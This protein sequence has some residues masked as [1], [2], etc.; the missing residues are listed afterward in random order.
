VLPAPAE[1]RALVIGVENYPRLGE[2]FR[3]PRAAAA[4]ADFARW[5]VRGRGVDIGSVELWLNPAEGVDPAQLCR[6]ADLDGI[7][8]RR[9]EWAAFRDAVETPQ[10]VFATGSFLMV[11]FCGHGLVSGFENAHYLVLPEASENQYHCVKLENWRALF[12]NELWHR[13]SHQLWTVDA[14]RNQWGVGLPLNQAGWEPGKA[15]PVKRCL[16]SSCAEGEVMTA[17]FATG[18]RYTGEL[19][20]CLQDDRAQPWPD[21]VQA[22]HHIAALLRETGTA[23]QSPTLMLESW[24]GV[25]TIDG[26][27][28]GQRLL[29]LLDQIGW[30]FKKFLPYV[31]RAQAM[32]PIGF[33]P[34]ANLRQALEQLAQLAPV[35]D[36]EPI[37]DFAAR[38]AAARDFPE[39]REW[40]ESSLSPRQK[41]ELAARRRED[42]AFLRLSLWYRSDAAQ[43]SMDGWLDV[44]D[45]G[46]G[47]LPWT[48]LDP[49]PVAPGQEL[50]VMGRWV[51]EVYSHTGMHDF[52]LEIELFLAGDLLQKADFDIATLRLADGGRFTVGKDC[53]AVLRCADRYKGGR[54]LQA[55]RSVAPGILARHAGSADPLRWAA[56]ADDP[57]RLIDAF[58][59]NDPAGPVWLGLEHEA[60]DA[61]AL[62]NAAMSSGLPAAI[63]LRANPDRLTREDLHGKMRALLGC[64]LEALPAALKSMRMNEQDLA[65]RSVAVMLEDPKRIPEIIYKARQPGG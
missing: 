23:R 63:W 24:D 20:K 7:V 36:I 13:F 31:M 37:V 34:P 58:M 39:L 17:G 55:L 41:A 25:Q 64:A 33:A 4:A 50:E 60:G 9:F 43:A 59:A 26:G 21:F 30:E 51:D 40:A 11:Y 1:V 18:P 42:R 61:G 22:F 10:G 56:S 35:D 6:D 57:D 8:H 44:L 49:K 65:A 29:E 28:S 12:S 53:P 19:L 14:C 38:V 52:D 46:S 47:V 3:V 48:R 45:A 15:T 54:K 32:A 62:L 2:A 5:L 16:L 27:R